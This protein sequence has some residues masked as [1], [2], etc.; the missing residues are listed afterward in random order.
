MIGNTSADWILQI[1]SP[2]VI[3]YL[4]QITGFTFSDK[5]LLDRFK[6]SPLTITK[7]VRAY[8]QIV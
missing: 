2:S 8:R 1:T 3:R 6:D 5:D 4:S 7:F